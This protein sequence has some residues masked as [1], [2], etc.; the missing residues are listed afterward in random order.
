M[1]EKDF[2]N[3]YI[4]VFK[5]INMRYLIGLL[6]IVSIFSCNKKNDNA[7]LPPQT[8]VTSD[9]SGMTGELT[10][11]TYY[12]KDG[13]NTASTVNNCDVFLYANYEDI[14]T[15]LQSYTNNL[16]IYR[17]Y[18]DGV[19]Y[20]Y[21][22]YINYGDYYVLGTKSEAGNQYEMISIVQ[23]RPN[24]DEHLNLYLELN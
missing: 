2:D 14:Q 21:F 4:Y 11:H 22:G 13:G 16:A 19:N 1:F 23:V 24:R 9:T 8:V 12:Y 20:A 5:F 18:E 3:Y 15:D 10:V 6:I 17:L 7:E